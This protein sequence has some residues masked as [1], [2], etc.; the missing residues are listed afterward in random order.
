MTD[1]SDLSEGKLQPLSAGL[2]EHELESAKDRRHMRRA[3]FYGLGLI[4]A[5]YLIVLLFFLHRILSCPEQ[6]VV[7]GDGATHFAAEL[8]MPE[9][10]VRWLVEQGNFFLAS[11]ASMFAVSEVAMKYRLKNLGL[12]R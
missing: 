8:L 9:H 11:L 3:A 6:Y 7:N 5:A 12:L 4:C 10:S 1:D 2:T